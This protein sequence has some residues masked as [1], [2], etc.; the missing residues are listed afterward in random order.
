MKNFTSKTLNRT[1]EA[2][3]FSPGL[4]KQGG[5]SPHDKY[6]KT[7]ESFASA[8]DAEKKGKAAPRAAQ[9]NSGGS[10]AA[11]V[12]FEALEIEKVDAENGYTVGE[13]FQQAEKLNGKKISVR[14]KVV[15]F[16]PMIMDRNWIHLQDGTGNAMEN[17]HDLGQSP[18]HLHIGAYPLPVQK[19]RR[20]AESVEKLVFIEEGDPIIETKLR[21]ILPEVMP[22]S[23]KLDGTVPRR[24]ELNP[25]NIRPSLGLAPRAAEAEAARL[26]ARPPQLCQGCPHADTYRAIKEAC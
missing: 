2:I 11:I 21:G 15:K 12:P 26:P 8:V 19:I 20:L 25:D 7:E 22:M 24:G 18:S 1:F 3:I 4:V 10:L 14:G 6:H 23:G 17:Q 5:T 9:Q 13:I 16:T